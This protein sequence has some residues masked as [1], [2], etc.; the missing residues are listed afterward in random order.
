MAVDFNAAKMLFWAKNLGASFCRTLTLGHQGFNCPRHRFRRAVQDFGLKGLP[1]EIERCFQHAPFGPLYA[2][3][4]FR[5]LSAKEV[6][7]VDRSN[8]EHATMLHDL[9]EP[10]PEDQKQRYDFV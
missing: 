3:E 5:F 2:D 7:S 8:F 4:L 1:D 10:F 6:V 9:N